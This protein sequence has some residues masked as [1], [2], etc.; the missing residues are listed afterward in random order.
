MMHRII[1]TLLF[2]FFLLTVEAQPKFEVRAA[3]LTSAYGL[4]WPKTRANSPQGIQKQKDELITILDK[5]KAANFNTILFQARLRG[6]VLYPSSI[7][8]FDYILTGTTGKDPGYDPL[9]F[10]IEECHKRGM[11]CHAWMVAIPLGSKTHVAALG[12]SSVTKKQ[13][14]ICVSYKNEY[15]LNPGHPQTKEYLMQ[16]VR[17]VVGR[18]DVDG[19]QF[20]Y[21]RYPEYA[22][23]FSDKRE[24]AKY[25]KGL[26][27]NEWRRNNLTEIVRYIKV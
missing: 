8:P 12:S 23:A 16:L 18:Y 25:G 11:E 19:V 20:D 24:F 21:L 2:F 4:D 5:L 7:E 10:A 15:F 9:A 13:K 17:E 27:L 3:W 1:L 22:L 26:T 14:E 6:D